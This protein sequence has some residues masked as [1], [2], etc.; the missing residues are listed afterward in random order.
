MK[1]TKKNYIHQ[2]K[3]C[4]KMMTLIVRHCKKK[5]IQRNMLGKETFFFKQWSDLI[6]TKVQCSNYLTSVLASKTFRWRVMGGK[7]HMPD[8]QC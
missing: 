1:Y 3:F 2:D 6:F 4:Q 5:K 8:F 7:V